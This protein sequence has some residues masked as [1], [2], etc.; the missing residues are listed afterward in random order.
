MFEKGVGHGERDRVPFPS[1][2]IYI[3]KRPGRMK[4]KG[5]ARTPEWYWG[6]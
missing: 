2:F 4:E 5:A 1:F 3:A 6:Q